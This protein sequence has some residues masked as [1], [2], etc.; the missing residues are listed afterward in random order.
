MFGDLER[1][2]IV[3]LFA[4]ILGINVL[5]SSPAVFFSTE[6][7]WFQRPWFYPPE[8]LFPI[9][10]TALFTLMGIAVFLIWRRGSH[11][12]EVRMALALFAIQLAINLVWTPAF[13]GMRR[14]GL[15]LIIIL[16]LWVA[17]GLTIAAFYRV[18]RTAALLLVPYI[19]WV[20][21]AI[22]LNLAIYLNT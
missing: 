9:V 8:I 7:D 13:F 18:S 11:R 20:T 16:L 6:T 21:F 22:S 4:S 1:R 19:A 3:A 2:E 17:I 5:G 14:P 12:R 10:W 15:A